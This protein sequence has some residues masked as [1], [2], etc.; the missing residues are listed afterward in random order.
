MIKLGAEEGD[1]GRHIRSL[2]YKY[3]YFRVLETI[4]YG[5]IGTFLVLFMLDYLSYIEVGILF[6]IGMAIQAVS[7]Y[8]T[9]AL[10]DF[11]G[12]KNILIIA[13]VLHIASVIVILT[14][15]SFIHFLFFIVLSYLGASQESGALQAWYD[16]SYRA[17]EQG[18]DV[19]RTEY[20]AFMGSLNIA[21]RAL[22]AGMIIVSGLIAEILSRR[23][24]FVFLLIVNLIHL[25]ST[26][27]IIQKPATGRTRKD[28]LSYKSIV[29][30]GLKFVTR[31]KA[32]FAVFL[33]IALAMGVVQGFWGNLIL[34]P[35]YAAYAKTDS[36]T[37]VLRFLTWGVGI[38]M[39][40]AVIKPSK[41][42]KNTSRA[43]QWIIV[44]AQT[45]LFLCVTIF[46]FLLPPLQAFDM[47]RFIGLAAAFNVFSILINLRDILELRFI[48]DFVPD[49]SRNSLYSL[50]STLAMV[51]AVPSSI[52]GGFVI[53]YTGLLCGMVFV[54]VIEFIGSVSICAGLYWFR[55][56]TE[57]HVS[58]LP[59][60][61]NH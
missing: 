34:F 3:A 35:L 1:K 47:R 29:Y 16:N 6:G 15:T 38:L 49:Q 26:P 32:N 58:T 4:G 9:G 12:Q 59:P 8:P 57:K 39:G 27:F 14:A 36:L 31:S 51:I 7:D 28:R 54:T 11:I 30:M 17:L 20:G 60:R 24:L 2:N 61:A 55:V 45:G 10:G 53:Q 5:F 40:I 23:S 43:L 13:F 33:G 42:I 37:A 46:Y 21:T 52:I 56:D 44:P 19:K 22:G 18:F 25:I 48:I 41:L 50:L